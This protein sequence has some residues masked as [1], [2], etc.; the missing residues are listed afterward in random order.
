MARTKY[1]HTQQE[2]QSR[3]VGC[4]RVLTEP[5]TDTHSRK[6]SPAMWDVLEYGQDHILKDWYYKNEIQQFN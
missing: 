3:T 2:E 6:N 1:R 4:S 5:R